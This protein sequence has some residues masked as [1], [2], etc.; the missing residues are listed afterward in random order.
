MITT[1]LKFNIEKTKDDYEI[2]R[3]SKND[4]WIYIGSK[5]NMKLEIDKFLDE[6]GEEND[7]KRVFLIYGFG[8]GEHIKALR[9]KFVKNRILV[10]EPNI[11]LRNYINDISWIKKDKNIRVLCC[12]KDDL[13]DN[14]EKYI[15]EEIF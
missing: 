5:Y 12:E 14:I 10:F 6:V 7:E 3:V 4:K 9:S 2:L 1:D 8:A 11:S 15:H 13:V